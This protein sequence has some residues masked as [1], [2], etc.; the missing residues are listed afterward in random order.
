M[1]RF[2][3]LICLL[4]A[5]A[6][7]FQM[8]RLNEREELWG[9]LPLA[10]YLL[11]WGAIALFLSRRNDP[12]ANR[13]LLLSTAS[14]FLLG[15]GFPGYLPLPFLLLVAWVPLLLLARETASARSL[16]WHG[17]NTF[18][19]YNILAA[20]WITNTAFGAG[21]FAVFF[22][23]A[24]MSVPWMFFVWTHRVSP[25]VAY[26]AFIAGWVSFEHFTFHWSMNWPWLTLGNGFAQ[27]PSLIQWYEV[28]GALGGSIW[29]LLVN[30][31]IVHW[32]SSSTPRRAPAYLLALALLPMVGSIIRFYTYQTPAGE[33]ITVS[34]IQ[35]N[36][37]PHYEKFSEQVGDQL[38][39]FI[40]LGQEALLATPGPVDYLV[41]PETSFRQIE[42]DRAG[43]APAITALLDALPP[44]RLGYLVAGIDAYHLFRPGEPVTEAVRYLPQSDG[45]EL[46][47]EALNGALQ[48]DPVTR[49]FQTYRKGVFVPGAE[50]FPFRKV[51]FFLEPLVNSVG[52]TVAGR[53]TQTQ[54]TPL[55]GTAR[56][57]PV[58]CYESVFGEYFTD[59]IREGAQVAFVITNDGWWDNT[60]GHRQH[61]YFSSLRAIE[62][63][64]DV[65]RSAN[66]GACAFIDQRGRILSSTDYGRRGYLNGT[67]RLNDAITPY[68]RFPRLFARIAML[69]TAMALLSNLAHTLRRRAG[70]L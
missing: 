55:D 63:R 5:L 48:V 2:A 53:G 8:Y 16:F 22:G 6:C 19:L 47:F 13:R 42:E 36:I 66:M 50:S 1:R 15:V 18:A 9:H 58:I 40:R 65:V 43:T 28:T 44:D 25:K 31:L 59:Y 69:L 11:A 35:P 60:S 54:R 33:T 68:V 32:Y 46:A 70:T 26:L 61:L 12:P 38:A 14:G 10:F 24:M 51:L 17:A 62:T 49:D 29:I 27:W 20:F 39:I 52:G 67:L 4:L 45:T 23:T 34:S 7:A 37:E 3:P 56:V 57:A 64:R 21:V 41:Y 30:V